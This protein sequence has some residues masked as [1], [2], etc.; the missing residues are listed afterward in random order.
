MQRGQQK[1]AHEGRDP[2][3]DAEGQGESRQ[4][5]E[6]S[7]ADGP[8]G[9]VEEPVEGE[10]PGLGQA[11]GE[12]RPIETLSTEEGQPVAAAE[13]EVSKDKEP[14]QMMKAT[15]II[16][17]HSLT[18]LIHHNPPLKHNKRNKSKS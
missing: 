3:P 5:P 13:E 14:Y 17:R 1:K 6:D 15:L 12:L 8:P 11:S 7:E 16:V 4:G 2:G 9:I 18:N 10:A